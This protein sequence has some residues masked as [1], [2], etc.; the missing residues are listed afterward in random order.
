M[1]MK[2]HAIPSKIL[3]YGSRNKNTQRAS[4]HFGKKKWTAKGISAFIVQKSACGPFGLLT[5]RTPYMNMPLQS[6][7]RPNFGA[8]RLGTLGFRGFPGYEDLSN[9]RSTRTNLRQTPNVHHILQCELALSPSVAKKKQR[10]KQTKQEKK[11][12]WH[13]GP[14]RDQ[15][16]LIKLVN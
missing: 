2:P 8:Q 7:N 16:P 4:D 1:L 11:R 3:R 6:R 13:T 12:T 9:T 10:T 15:K 5:K 14:R